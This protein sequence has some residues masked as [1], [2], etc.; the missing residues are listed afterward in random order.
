MRRRDFLIAL[1]SSSFYFSARRLFAQLNSPAD[2]GVATGAAYE[3]AVRKAIELVGGIERFVKPGDTVAIKPNMSFNSPP[4]LKA[5]T[6]P[7]IVGT[8]VQLCFEAGADRVQVF[9]RTLTSP[10]LSY[11][12]SGIEAAARS[13]GAK[14]LYVNEPKNYRQ[15]SIRGA[16]VLEKT[17]VNRYVLD[18]DVFIN[19]PVAKSHS[20]AGLTLG[21]KNLMGITGDNRSRWHWDLGENLS[22]FN[23]AVRSH[24]TVIDGTNIMLQGG[25][26]GGKAS[27]LKR[28][29]TVI[30]AANVVHADC[31][32]AKLFGRSP[33]SLAYLR[34]AQ[35]KGIGNLTGYS[36]VRERV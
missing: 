29:D 27:Y 28:M 10:K 34:L 26:T 23:M 6:D 8:V 11:R 19:L 2:V 4:E 18:A 5:N 31:E 1:L 35:K 16:S 30:A 15:I 20:L 36:L 3:R 22:D 17:T 12:T 21:M 24:L 13:A 7:R 33:D 9:D 32:G 25:P 14:V